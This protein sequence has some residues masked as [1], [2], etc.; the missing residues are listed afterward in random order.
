LT[1]LTSF[2]LPK[3]FGKRSH[4][5]TMS[6]HFRSYQKHLRAFLEGMG[7][8]IVIVVLLLSKPYN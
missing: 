3:R 1:T 8:E 6:Y 4:P 7:R 5:F 2:T